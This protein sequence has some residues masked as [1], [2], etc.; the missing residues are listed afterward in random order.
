[1]YIYLAQVSQVRLPGAG[2][3]GISTWFKFHKVVYLVQVHSRGNLM[4]QVGLPDIKQNYLVQNTQ[5]VTHVV[6]HIK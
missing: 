3:T 4:L 6:T 5:V 1:M 2:K